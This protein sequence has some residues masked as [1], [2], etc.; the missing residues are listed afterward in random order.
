MH[1]ISQLD[2]HI[3]FLVIDES[4]H[5]CGIG[6]MLESHGEKISRERGC[7]RIVFTQS[8]ELIGRRSTVMNGAWWLISFIQSEGIER[9]RNIS[10]SYSERRPRLKKSGSGGKG[11]ES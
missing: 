2:V 3:G 1:V 5:S 4:C 11:V 7:N 10:R 8:R 9:V 6:K